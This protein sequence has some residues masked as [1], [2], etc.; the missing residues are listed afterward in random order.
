[1]MFVDP[2]LERDMRSDK[3]KS[4]EKI[5]HCLDNLDAWLEDE[6]VPTAQP[7]EHWKP[8]IRRQPKGT[9]LVIG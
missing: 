4:Q 8:A 7:F 2:D 1:M 6:A 5:T 3:T 9:C